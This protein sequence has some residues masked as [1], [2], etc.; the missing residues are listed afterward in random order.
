MKKR[1]Q[2]QQQKKYNFVVD[3]K[4]TYIIYTM[5]FLTVLSLSQELTQKRKSMH[6]YLVCIHIQDYTMTLLPSNPT[7]HRAD[8]QNHTN[9]NLYI[10][11]LYNRFFALKT[12]LILLVHVVVINESHYLRLF[13]RYCT[14]TIFSLLH[15]YIY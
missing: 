7:M 15:S 9:T 10:I 3:N 5:F 1:K 4:P 2:I 13:L 11:K 6:H 14:T 12:L 8:N